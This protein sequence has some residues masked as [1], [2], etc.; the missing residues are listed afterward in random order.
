MFYVVLFVDHAKLFLEKTSK[1]LRWVLFLV[2]FLGSNLVAAQL[3]PITKTDQYIITKHHFSVEDG[4]ASREVTAA[5][6]DRDGFM[7]FGTSNGLSRY[8]GN[9]FKT[10]TKQ[11]FGLLQNEIASLSVD[12]YNHLIIEFYN[13][14]LNLKKNGDI[15]I[16]DLNNYTLHTLESAYSK[17]PFKAKDVVWMAN[18]VNKNMF[19]VTA[20]PFKVWKNDNLNGFKLLGEL[21]AWNTNKRIT[22]IESTE[23]TKSSIVQNG[24]MILKKQGCPNYLIT[25]GKISPF[26]NLQ[27][28][29]VFAITK[30]KSLLFYNS[31]SNTI[32]KGNFPIAKNNFE[33]HSL[34]PVQ[35]L[36]PV[37]D[38]Y[39]GLTLQHDDEASLAY[40]IKKGVYLISDKTP[41]LV[42][43]PE[44]ISKYTDFNIK[45]TFK[46]SRGIRWLCTN[47]GVIQISI[48]YNCFKSYFSRSQ[49]MEPTYNQVRGIYVENGYG[50]SSDKL[51]TMVYANVW[52]CLCVANVNSKKVLVHSTKKTVHFNAFLKH[53]GKFYIGSVNK[54]HE[55]RPSQNKIED[56]GTISNDDLNGA[57]IWSLKAVSDS[58]LLAGHIQGLS[59]FNRVS[60]ESKDLPYA[61]SKIP[62][63]NNVY[64]FIK[65]KTKG[66]V[67]VA[68]NG[69]FIIDKNNTVVDY[70]GTL[71]KDES[72]HLPM[73]MIYDMHEDRNGICWI[74]TNGEGLFRWDW[75]HKGNDK[76]CSVKQFNLD[77]GLPSMILY[78]IEE[79]AAN[80]LWIGTYNGLMRFNTL[81]YATSVY[82]VNE[83]LNHNEFNRTSSFKAADGTMYFGGLNGV[84]AFNPKQVMAF[85]AKNKP[86][87]KVT[88]LMK[89]SGKEHRLMDC[90]LALKQ[91]K[92]VVLQADDSFLILEFQLL[93]YMK[94]KHFY[95]YKL[96]GIDSEWNY[97]DENVIRLSG[98]PY[99]EYKMHVKAKM[100][101]GQWA[102]Q[103]IL[104]PIVVLKPFYIETWFIIGIVIIFGFSI[105]G[106][107][108][109]RTKKIIR[110]NHQLELKIAN[111]TTDLQKA[112]TDRERL[113]T[114][115][116]HRVKNNLHVI[117]GLLQLQKDELADP[118]SKAAFAEGQSRIESIALIHQN[119]YQNE[120]LGSIEFCSFIHNLSS[121]VANLYDN[122]TNPVAYAIK[123]GELFIDVDTA[124][125]LG[126]IVNEL[127][128]NSYKHFDS[129]K[130]G[131]TI[132]IEVTLL[133]PGQ[134]ELIF[135]DNG[136]GLPKHV[137]FETD[138][139]L[140]LKLIKGLAKQL[141]GKVIY[142][143]DKGS[144]FTVF[145]Q[146]SAIRYNS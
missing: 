54:V 92:E 77:Q 66:L 115:I 139:T 72:H 140:G 25:V 9:S 96:D 64:R 93:D 56:I 84:N 5:I 57:Y 90:L 21:P 130:K 14:D 131:K 31:T 113:L 74:A 10:F 123:K 106:F 35:H 87:F 43:K 142:H 128:T 49:V 40:S 134:Y 20:N 67:A 145:F 144:V 53:K 112:L 89:Y 3:E 58:I 73:T 99:G 11:N 103:S 100:A 61:S 129:R 116:H 26:P 68:E 55:Y 44:E 70:Y 141:S 19:F 138:K 33:I 37:V 4:L 81:T 42:A 135:R 28:E 146:D 125:P 143:F 45:A 88:S 120:A 39:W 24:S 1:D 18:D 50:G 47:S 83:G 27:N 127:L 102:K 8:D 118:F 2:L 97:I 133:A 124:V 136:G 110:E 111:R 41:L 75:Q 17:L 104:F 80:N 60:K 95:A 76:K 34:I 105:F 85:E 23:M 7:W 48:E 62:K 91:E 29:Y 98:L 94:R 36:P 22:D 79:D 109:Y 101:N 132:A 121:K 107:I 30:N 108:R 86:S 15:Q 117:N 51:T 6:E 52:Q 59:Q 119:L 13:K 12:K 32:S 65:T 126:L 71:V 82:T 63:A 78:R 16:I 114:E 69:L 122:P 46:D 38:Y 137:D